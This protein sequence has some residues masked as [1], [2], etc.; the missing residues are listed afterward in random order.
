MATNPK[1]LAPWGTY[2]PYVGPM[3]VEQF[4]QFPGEEGWMYELHE[5][6][7]IAVPGPGSVHAD[8]QGNL[9]STLGAYISANGLGRLRGTGCYNLPVPNTTE[10]LLCPD[11]S[12]VSPSNTASMPMRG[13]YP[14]GAPEM[15]IEIA[16]PGDTRPQV[17]KKVGIYL[18]AGVQ[19]VW[20]V[21]PRA[22]S[23][24]VWLPSLLSAPV[25]TFGS[26]DVITGVP[27]FPSFQ[28]PVQDILR[29]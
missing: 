14:V 3:T 12:Y 25:S 15:A 2:I 26:S 17:K 6:R 1:P 20:V 11:L 8:I 28:C 21:W 9:F 18:Q 19:V 5:G 23:I 16:S 24:D 7:V 27:I 4:E 10:E 13:S 22:G 29:P